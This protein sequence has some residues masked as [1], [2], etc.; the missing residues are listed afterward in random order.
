MLAGEIREASVVLGDFSQ[1]RFRKLLWVK[2][3]D[4]RAVGRADQFIELLKPNLFIASVLA[5]LFT[6]LGIVVGVPLKESIC[7]A[8][9]M[10]WLSSSV[11]WP[12]S[13]RAM[14]EKAAPLRGWL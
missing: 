3:C 10:A 12:A 1:L 7:L 2:P 14:S 11:A 9:C 5:D 6:F 4:L 8:I 13:S